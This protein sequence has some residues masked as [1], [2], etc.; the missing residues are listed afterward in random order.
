MV[1]H[2]YSLGFKV[3]RGVMSQIINGN[4]GF[5][6]SF[7]NDLSAYVHIG[8]QFNR[9]LRT[10]VTLGGDVISV[11]QT[12]SKKKKDEEHIHTILVWYTGQVTQ[13]GPEPAM[14]REAYLL[15][16]KL[17]TDYSEMIRV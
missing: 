5:A 9:M 13:S 4:Y 7:V 16:M 6:S 1:N 17:V 11:P 2:N 10:G 12:E 15:F 8:K 14:C 3:N